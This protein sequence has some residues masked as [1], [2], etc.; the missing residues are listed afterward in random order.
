MVKILINIL[1]DCGKNFYHVKKRLLTLVLK[2]RDLF[3]SC[4]INEIELERVRNEKLTINIK[5]RA[6]QQIFL[7]DSVK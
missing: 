4:V 5:V 6:T 2:L 3:E 1:Y 7:L